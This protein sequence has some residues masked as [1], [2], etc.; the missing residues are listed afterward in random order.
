VQIAINPLQWLATT[1]GWLDLALAPPRELMLERIAQ[2][3]FAAVMTDVPSEMSADEYRDL[4]AQY[5]L[6]PAP[7]YFSGPLEDLE[8]R[9]QVVE[10]AARQ[11]EVHRD[12]PLTEMF[13][14]ANMSP[15]SPRVMRPA[16]GAEESEDR[17]AAIAETLT[18]IGTATRN[19]GVTACL[20]QHVGSWIETENE[21][22]WLLARIDRELVALGPDTGH[23]AWA[24]VEPS[25]FISRH[26]DRVR[27]LHVKDIR[28]G[29]ATASRNGDKS[30]REV[31]REGLWVEPGRGDIDLHS[32]LAELADGT[33]QWAIVEVDSPDL[34]SPEESIA[35]CGAWARSAAGG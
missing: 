11:A 27:A 33:C 23:L 12:L 7:G 34:P 17:L 31:V 1:D 28:L 35:F 15:T 24:G 16:R 25:D 21:L 6:V 4:L 26:R 9:G 20:H 3:R 13:V 14:A 18:A 10:A 2:A 8:R 30:Y 19:Y 5:Q 29:I 22:E 32:I